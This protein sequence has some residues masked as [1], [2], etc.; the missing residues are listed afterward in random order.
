MV[1]CGT[2]IGRGEHNHSNIPYMI[3]ITKTDQVVMRNNI[4]IKATPITAEQYLRVQLTN[5]TADPVDKILKHYEKL[6]YKNVT[7]KEGR[8]YT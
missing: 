4:L 2:V 8:I 3:R 5:N 7:I 6:A 1:D